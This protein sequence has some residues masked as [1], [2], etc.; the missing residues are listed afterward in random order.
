MSMQR[1]LLTIATLAL[2][3][4]PAAGAWTWPT[5]GVVLRPFAFDPSHPY[6]SGQHR[7]LDV[8]GADGASVAAPAAG[9]VTF[10]G[11]VPSGGRTVT[12]ETPDEWSVTLVH[13]GSIAVTKGATVAEGDG[14][15]TIGPSGEPEVSAP[16]V[17]LG[18][19]RT[20]EPQGYVDPIVLLPVRPAAPPAS[21]ARPDPPP[22][23]AVA[24][25]PAAA[26]PPAL[27][28]PGPGASREPTPPATGATGEVTAPAAMPAP[29]M[30]ASPPAAVSPRPR[31]AGAATPAAAESLADADAAAAAVPVPDPAGIARPS[32]KAGRTVPAGARVAPASVAARA[33]VATA[34]GGTREA[35]PAPASARV[36][37]AAP[38][39]VA[40]RGGA[41][42]VAA[43]TT[44]ATPPAAVRR[45]STAV[46]SP[47][48]AAAAGN[49]SKD[50]RARHRL[51]RRAAAAPAATATVSAGV[52]AHADAANASRSRATPARTG[53][54]RGILPSLVTVVVALAT[55]G[56]VAVALLARRRRTRRSARIMA[57]DA[58]TEVQDPRS[59]SV[60]VCLRAPSPGTRRGLRRPLRRVCAVPPAARQRRAHGERHGR[61]RNARH[62]RRGSRGEIVR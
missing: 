30:A 25:P 21:Q 11:T 15:G 23:P 12:I 39:V 42:T 46:T 36:E 37:A 2:A 58:G 53:S 51:R 56:V 60:A 41:R 16:H 49:A 45:G 8:G 19:R 57:G 13:L 59:S 52:R 3:V 5:D 32:G 14:V 7:G 43:P 6:A 54:R 48:A 22:M 9:V 20:A 29:A 24:V 4:A 27:V 28:P 31:E 47:K 40:A 61:A 33:V 55:A 38:L 17:H 44:R 35:S 62:G 18:V 34:V 26:P 1:L 50:V 10:A